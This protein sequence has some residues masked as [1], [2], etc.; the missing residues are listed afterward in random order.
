MKKIIPIW[1]NQSTVT[2][3]WRNNKEITITELMKET[4]DAIR[5]ILIDVAKNKSTITYG[6]LAKKAGGQYHATSMGRL[7]DVL[8]IDCHARN[9]ISLAVVVVSA[10]TGEVGDAFVGDASSGR[11]SLYKYWATA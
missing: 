6:A 2:I 9:E 5:P 10:S 4:L 8:S 1:K 11:V 7:M 3:P